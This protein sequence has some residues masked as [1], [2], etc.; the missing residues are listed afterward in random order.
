MRLWKKLMKR[1]P[2]KFCTKEQF[3]VMQVIPTESVTPSCI[4]PVLLIPSFND[5]VLSYHV[6][7]AQCWNFQICYMSRSDCDVRTQIW[8]V[9]WMVIEYGTPMWTV[10]V[11]FDWPCTFLF[12]LCSQI[13]R[14]DLE[15][16]KAYGELYELHHKTGM[17]YIQASVLRDVS[18][19]HNIRQLKLKKPFSPNWRLREVLSTPLMLMLW[20][21]V[22]LKPTVKTRVHI[23]EKLASRA[24]SGSRIHLG[25][26]FIISL[27]I[28]NHHFLIKAMSSFFISWVICSY[29]LFYVYLECPEHHWWYLSSVKSLS[30]WWDIPWLSANRLTLWFWVTLPLFWRLLAGNSSQHYCMP[31]ICKVLQRSRI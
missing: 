2:S 7:Q 15:M 8:L 25:K 22:F 20:Y 27:K 6:Y 23:L 16:K 10:L 9:S 29:N 28:L 19:H 18:Y 24:T 30:K 12:L 13:K 5:F 14:L 1:W 11:L 4:F 21:D 3:T 17:L 26:V 31:R